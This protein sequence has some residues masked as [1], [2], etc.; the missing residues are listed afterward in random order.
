MLSCFKSCKLFNY[1]TQKQCM[2]LKIYHKY[3]QWTK[4]G[5]ALCWFLVTSHTILYFLRAS[6]HDPGLLFSLG[7]ITAAG[8]PSCTQMFISVYMKTVVKPFLRFGLTRQRLEGLKF[9]QFFTCK[10]GT[11]A[12]PGWYFQSNNHGFPIFRLV[13]K[14]LPPF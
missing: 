8:N 2:E 12:N 9:R 14:D 6:L 13:H 5:Q 10:Q 1:T 7:S 4:E 11:K 3:W